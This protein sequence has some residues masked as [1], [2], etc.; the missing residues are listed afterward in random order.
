MQVLYA[1]T[2]LTP[3]KTNNMLSNDYEIKQTEKGQN[4]VCTT[5]KAK[6]PKIRNKTVFTKNCVG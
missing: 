2:A 6:C 1:Y 4:P 5:P 3:Y